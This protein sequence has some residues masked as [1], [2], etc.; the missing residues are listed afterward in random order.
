[1]IFFLLTQGLV[2]EA[3]LDKFNLPLYAPS[4]KELK[5]IIEKE[6]SFKLLQLE[7]FKLKWDSNM[8]DN[9]EK[10]A[11]IFDEKSKAK[12]IAGNMRAVQE[13]IL[14]E[15]FGEEIMDD[16]F[17]RYGK[18]AIEYMKNGKGN[19]NNVVMS[20]VKRNEKEEVV[21]V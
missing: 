13:P 16:L 5:Q 6:G 7:T 10:E 1:M 19:I 3:K 15:H 21:P 17:E 20:L 14:V 4:T 12:Y 8:D 2:E 18:K 11:T 9:S